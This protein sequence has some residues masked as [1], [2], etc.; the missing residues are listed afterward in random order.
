MSQIELW[1][2]L[3]P[4]D[5]ILGSQSPRRVELLEALGIRFRQEA[6]PDLDERYPEGLK[7]DEVALYIS[8]QKAEAYK[9]LM[10]SNSLLITA[11]TTVVLG[12]T[13]L[14]K[15][16][17]E[18]EA[19]AMLLSLQGRSHRVVTGLT[20]SSVERSWSTQDIAQ[21]HFTPL[22][23]AE[24]RYYVEHYHPLDKA[25]AY[26]IQEWIGYRAIKGIEGSFYTVMGLPTHRLI[27]GLELFY[28]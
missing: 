20:L 24:V 5:I 14:G 13:I 15:P 9:P 17:S 3:E 16:E 18:E 11:D 19:I 28:Q 8:Q 27:E 12:D 10:Q 4:W 26:G 2:R 25:G 6:M 7:A 21:V 1:Q 22:T 23:E